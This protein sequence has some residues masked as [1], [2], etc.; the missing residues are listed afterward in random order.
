MKKTLIVLWLIASLLIPCLCESD[1]IGF[2]LIALLNL[3]V[4]VLVAFSACPEI[5]DRK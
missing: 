2:L 1:N 4:A 5:F 3:I